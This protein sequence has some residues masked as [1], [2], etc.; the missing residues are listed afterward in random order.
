MHTSPSL[1]P[2]YLMGPNDSQT[3][4]QVCGVC[5]V[6]VMWL[7]RCI[8]AM[9]CHTSVYQVWATSS[10][11]CA[12]LPYARWRSASRLDHIFVRTGLGSV[13]HRVHPPH[14]SQGQRKTMVPHQ[15]GPRERWTAAQRALLQ[16]S[17]TPTALLC[18]ITAA[19]ATAAYPRCLQLLLH[20]CGLCRPSAA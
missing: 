8:D 9:Y 20:R 19:Q 18:R 6:A 4:H 7:C 15:Q 11:S 13:T 3:V 5:N 17:L 16:V 2:P 10:R 1:F 12:M 14:A